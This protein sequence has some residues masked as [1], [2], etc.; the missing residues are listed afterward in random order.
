MAAILMNSTEFAQQMEEA[1]IPRA[2]ADVIA[3]GLATMVVHNFDALVTKDYLD[4]RF[5]EFEARIGR[6]MDRQFAEVERRFAEI[7]QRFA[8]QDGRFNLVYWMQGITIACVLIPAIHSF[9]G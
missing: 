3:K 9:L 5:G 8:E 7:D 6:E 1:G 4:V 2:Q